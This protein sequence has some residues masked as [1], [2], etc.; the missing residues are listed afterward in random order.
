MIWY[1]FVRKWSWSNSVVPK[2]GCTTPLG[3]VGL[4]RGVLKVGPSKHNVRL[5]MTEVTLDQILGKW[6]HLIKPTY[7]IKNF[8]TVKQLLNVL[9]YFIVTVFLS[10]LCKLLF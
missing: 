8:L 3:A 7:C 9:S 2:V 10:G 4:P 5:F 1:V 6:Y